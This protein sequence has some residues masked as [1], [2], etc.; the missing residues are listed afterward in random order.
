MGKE[1]RRTE[2]WRVEGRSVGGFGQLVNNFLF[3]TKDCLLVKRRKVRIRNG[4]GQESGRT[5][6]W[7]TDG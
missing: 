1:S 5:T 4:K 3:V 6:E 2:T 7:G